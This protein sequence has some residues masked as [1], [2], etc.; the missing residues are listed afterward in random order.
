MEAS[1]IMKMVEDAVYNWFFIIGVIVSDDDSTLR[2]VLKHPSKGAQG[3]VLNSSKVKLDEETPDPSSLADPSHH[4][5]VVAK[6]TFPSS[7][8][9]GL[10]DVDAPKK[11]LSDPRKIGGAW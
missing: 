11:M 9:V 2:A 5:K 3:Q 7:M 6:H 4:A 1:E 10:S 8:K